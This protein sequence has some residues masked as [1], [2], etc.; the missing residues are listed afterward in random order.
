[1]FDAFKIH[2]WAWAGKFKKHPS[3]GRDYWQFLFAHCFIFAATFYTAFMS[4]KFWYYSLGNISSAS[5]LAWVITFAI[6][7][8]AFVT[9][10]NIAYYLN[11][12]YRGHFVS[13]SQAQTFKLSLVIATLVIGFDVFANLKGVEE[14]AH[15]ST[16]D[17]ISNQTIGI[18]DSFQA[19][20][21]R[22]ESSMREDIA[23]HE[24]AIKKLRRNDK[25]NC[26]DTNCE[27]GKVGKKSGSPH[28][29]GRLTKFGKAAIDSHK[30]QIN[31]IE[32]E[33][34]GRIAKIES[35]QSI[36]LNEHKKDRDLSLQQYNRHV[37]LKID[38]HSSFVKLLYLIVLFVSLLVTEYVR[39]GLI[40]T[41]N[42]DVYK[43]RD[44]D[45]RM[46]QKRMEL[47]QRRGEKMIEEQ[48]KDVS[49]K[50]D[51]IEEGA[52]ANKENENAPKKGFL[53]KIIG[54][55]EDNP[56]KKVLDKYEGLDFEVSKGDEYTGGAKG[57]VAN[58]SK[59][60]FPN[61]VLMTG[62]E[63]ISA[64]RTTTKPPV[65]GY[66][67]T[68]QNCGQEKTMK[69]AR[70][71]YCSNKCRIDSHNKNSNKKVNL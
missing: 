41:K 70:A 49:E 17:V 52:K 29:A 51:G 15:T 71:K 2:Y 6:A 27:R 19:R 39:E 16:D 46:I 53:R 44:L 26:L 58:F 28:W 62:N 37:G 8:V 34:R 43:E 10:G 40:F 4:Y 67:I 24:A 13:K 18:D 55:P 64:I 5:E 31:S 22:I 9:L 65:K 21:D 32:N 30:S 69:S 45:R 14:H 11:C 57:S 54:D 50:T 35:N 25:H 61:T 63:T 68:C 20:I 3:L 60:K 36:A 66:K 59:K 47:E 42:K 33:A 1:M 48:Y 38:G 23:K 7:A 12:K 56:V